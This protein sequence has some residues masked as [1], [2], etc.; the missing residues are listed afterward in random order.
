MH[1]YG[2]Y[3]K[4]NLVVCKSGRASKSSAIGLNSSQRGLLSYAGSQIHKIKFGSCQRDDKKQ[5][6]WA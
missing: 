2:K 4:L 1:N 3:H 5:G 6:I